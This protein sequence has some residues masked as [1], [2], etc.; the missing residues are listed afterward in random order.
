MANHLRGHELP[1]YSVWLVFF[2]GEEAIEQWS[3][4]DSTY[5]SRHLAARWQNAG[6]LKRIRG[7][8]L[9]D[10]LGDRDL[11]VDRDLNSTPWMVDLVK[12][13]ADHLHYG[14][15]FFRRE[16]PFEDDHLAFVQ[17]GVPSVDVIDMDYGP[18]TAALP[19]GYH[20]TV[21]DTLDKLSARSLTIAGD[22]FL[23]SVRLLNQR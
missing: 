19:D 14:Q 10:M 12:Q 4:S 2:D 21:E 9:A 20:H 6:T 5:G 7:F 23:E 13:A 17:R 11:N 1:G 22:V 3:D 16:N 15:Y 8:L 18:H